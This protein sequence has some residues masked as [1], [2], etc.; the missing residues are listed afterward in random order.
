MSA[1][2]GLLLQE[3]KEL[4]DLL[5]GMIHSF[6]EADDRDLCSHI[7]NREFGIPLAFLVNM[8]REPGR[9]FTTLTPSALSRRL[10]HLETVFVHPAVWNPDPIDPG[11]LSRIIS[12]ILLVMASYAIA[13]LQGVRRKEA[14]QRMSQIVDGISGTVQDPLG[15]LKLS[16]T[17][18]H[19]LMARA[20]VGG[21]G[22]R[23]RFLQDLN[24]LMEGPLAM[25]HRIS[26]EMLRMDVVPASGDRSKWWQDLEHRA[27]RLPG[28]DPLVRS[29]L[30]EMAKGWRSAQ[31]FIQGRLERGPSFK[32]AVRLRLAEYEA[33]AG[34]PRTCMAHLVALKKESPPALY[35]PFIQALES[36]CRT[37]WHRTDYGADAVPRR[38][39]CGLAAG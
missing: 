7:L 9:V 22:V 31:C 16:L 23:S 32:W 1:P 6:P 4:M 36:F 27:S 34:H 13:D 37:Y 11:R 28:V 33:M 29:R 25:E 15:H 5:A 20:G 2:A 14:F 26:L 8:I 19:G 24:R 30:I 39:K 17:T 3:Q 35:R 12:Q 38:E 18:I 21:L 10:D